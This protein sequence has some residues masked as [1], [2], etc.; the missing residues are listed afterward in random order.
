MT[1][2]KRLIK[3]IREVRAVLAENRTSRLRIKVPNGIGTETYEIRHVKSEANFKLNPQRPAPAKH[4][5][6]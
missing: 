1:E 2:E 5:R 4:R 6:A 3:L